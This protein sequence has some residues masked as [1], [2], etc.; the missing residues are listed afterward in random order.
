M[1]ACNNLSSAV[2]RA[3]YCT[4]FDAQIDKL[5]KVVG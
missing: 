3:L 2:L 4:Q 1:D 5:A